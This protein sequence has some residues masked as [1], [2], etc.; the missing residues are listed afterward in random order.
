MYAEVA[1]GGKGLRIRSAV[2]PAAWPL[3]QHVEVLLHMLRVMGKLCASAF[4]STP[5][6]GSR[7]RSSRRGTTGRASG[8]RAARLP[9]APGGDDV[10]ARDEPAHPV[11]SACTAPGERAAGHLELGGPHGPGSRTAGRRGPP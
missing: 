4:S 6:A 9:G 8:V 7:S 11:W 1:A 5:M 2:S 10:T 3:G